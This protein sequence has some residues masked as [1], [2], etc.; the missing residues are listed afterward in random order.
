MMTE[1]RRILTEA[2]DQRH[3]KRP[4]SRPN[5]QSAGPDVRISADEKYD[6]PAVPRVTPIEKMMKFARISGAGVRFTFRRWRAP[7]PQGAAIGPRR[8]HRDAGL[9][10][11]RDASG[12]AMLPAGRTPWA[13]IFD[14]MHG[15][16]TGLPKYCAYVA[17]SDQK[18]CS[19]RCVPL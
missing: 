14:P 9:R 11:R 5:A 8:K 6:G 13:T 17:S 10:P 12:A 4:A 19:M 3:Q 2:M 16:A 15:M 18:N 7:G 1:E